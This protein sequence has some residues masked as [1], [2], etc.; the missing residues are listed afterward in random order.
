MPV[1]T[2]TANTLVQDEEISWVL[3]EKSNV[4]RAAA[5]ICDRLAVRLC[6]VT[7][8]RVGA[9]RKGNSLAAGPRSGSATTCSM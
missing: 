3:T 9:G 1:D 7:R 5:L 4:Y 8:R 6:G 2:D